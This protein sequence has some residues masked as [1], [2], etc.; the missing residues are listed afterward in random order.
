MVQLSLDKIPISP[1]WD[2]EEERMWKQAGHQIGALR[3]V[4]LEDQDPYFLIDSVQARLYAEAGASH[5]EFDK[6]SLMAQEQVRLMEESCP[7]TMAHLVPPLRAI[8]AHCSDKK[9]QLEPELEEELTVEEE[10]ALVTA[11]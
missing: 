7:E 6:L 8:D 2:E 1:P 10:L 5:L 4:L 11:Q 3:P 9:I